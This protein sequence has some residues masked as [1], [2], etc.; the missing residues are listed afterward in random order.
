MA[1]F[2]QMSLIQGKY[3]GPEEFESHYGNEFVH[4][5]VWSYPLHNTVY[6]FQWDE[7]NLCECEVTV[8]FIEEEQK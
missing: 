8:E 6:E 2:E 7:R 5:I 1:C 3:G 4:S